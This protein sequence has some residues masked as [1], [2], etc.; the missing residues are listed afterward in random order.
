M[1]RQPLSRT[2]C[3]FEVECVSKAGTQEI[4]IVMGIVHD[5]LFSDRHPME[6]NEKSGGAVEGL[7]FCCLC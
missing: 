7:A 1:S 4:A 6:S 3:Y 5:V 2:N